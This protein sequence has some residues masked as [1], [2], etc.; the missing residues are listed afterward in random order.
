MEF[1]DPVNI[2]ESVW[3]NC[4][5]KS[6]KNL[7]GSISTCTYSDALDIIAISGVGGTIYILDQETKE[8]KGSIDAHT[9]EILMMKFYDQ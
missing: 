2:T 6:Y 4:D 7:Y 9:Q 3:P 1:Y 8:K 5:R